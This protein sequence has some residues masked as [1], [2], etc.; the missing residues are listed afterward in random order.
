MIIH[1]GFFGSIF[2]VLLIFRAGFVTPARFVCVEVAGFSSGRLTGI[3]ITFCI[4]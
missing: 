2:A 4:G 1:M 3:I